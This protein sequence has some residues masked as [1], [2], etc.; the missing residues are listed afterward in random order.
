MDMDSA[1]FNLRA[2]FAEG[3]PLGA[4]DWPGLVARLGAERDLRRE[5]T[6]RIDAAASFS[7]GAA[8]VLES[9]FEGSVNGEPAVNPAALAVGKAHGGITPVDGAKASDAGN[10]ARGQE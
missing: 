3:E 4:V 1:T 2:G 5:L 6:S 9:V 8:A 10:E 7:T